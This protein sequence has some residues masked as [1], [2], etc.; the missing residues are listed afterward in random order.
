VIILGTNH[1]GRGASVVAT[2]KDFVT[3][4][5]LTRTDSGFI[6]E[7]EERCGSLRT[8]EYDH[9]REHSVELQLLICQHLW[10]ADAFE[11]VAVLCPDPCGPTGTR[12]LDGNGIDLR[13]FGAALREAIAK[14]ST[15]TLLIAG[16]DLSHVGMQFGDE[17]SLDEDFC[18]E[19]GAR[20]EAALAHVA[21]NQPDAFITQVAR[22]D[23]PTRVC[24]AGCIFTAMTALPDANVLLLRYHQAVDE[25]A[26]AGVTCA[27]A[28]F[29]Q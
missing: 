15:D 28:V 21:A 11:M 13:A 19:V 20:D 22:E 27:A 4:L 3:P 14:N 24:S 10:G 26:Q 16:A 2:G 8:H 18:A 17:R 7:L 23:N 9:Q 25:Q 12:P 6:K 29:V 5:G 1:F